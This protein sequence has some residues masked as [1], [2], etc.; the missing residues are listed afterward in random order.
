[1]KQRISCCFLLL[2]LSS[3]VVTAQSLTVTGIVTDA[4]TE[5]P[6][7]GVSVLLDGTSQGTLTDIDGKY[8]FTVPQNNQLTFTYI[9][10]Q[11]YKTSAKTNVLNIQLEPQAYEIEDVIVV[12]TR[13]KKS[14][15]TGAIGG[16]TEKQL[17]EVPTIDLST[18]MQGKVPG[19]FIARKDAAPGSDITVRVRGINSINYGQEPVYV[20]DGMVVDQGLKLINPDD[21]ASIEVLKDASSTALY[22]S[23]ASN[24]VVVITTKKGQKGEGQVN[25][26]GFVTVSKYQ[27]RLKQLN[28]RQLF[29]LRVD[30]YA[31]AY[32]DVNPNANRQDFINNSLLINDSETNIAFSMEELENGL[33]GIT[34][35]WVDPLI[36]TGFTQNHALSFSGSTGKTTYYLGFT[37]SDEKGIIKNTGYQ[38]YGGKVSLE[39]EVKSWLKIGTNTILSQG[40]RDILSGDEGDPYLTAFKGNPLQTIDKDRYYMYWQGVAQMGEYNPLL[41]LDIDRKEIHNRVLSS[42]YAEVNPLKNLFF[43][44]TFAVDI[45]NK[46]DNRYVPSHTGQSQRDNYEGLGWQWRSN[47]LYWQW[48][49][50]VSYE[51]TFNEKHRLFGLFSTSISKKDFNSVTTDGYKFPFDDLGY[52]NMGFASNKELNKI[53]SDYKASTLVSYI[54]R[55]NYS[56]ESKYL[57]T[58]TVRRDGSSKFAKDNRWGTFPSFSAAWNVQE[59]SFMDDITWLSQLKLRAG[60][61]IVGNQNIPEFTYLTLFNPQYSDG[62]IGL[63]VDGEDGKRRYQNE[64]VVWEK[65]KQWNVGLDAGVWNDRITFSFDAFHMT[66][67]DLLM[68]MN[69]YP[70]FGYDYTIANVAELKNR[71]V[72]FSINAQLIQTKDFSWS[73]SGNIAHDKNEIT[74]LYNGL[75]VIWNGGSVTDRENQLFVGQSLNNIYAYKLDR[76]AQV[77]DQE[78]LD[79]LNATDPVTGEPN[80][81]G[82]KKIRPGDYL[83]YDRNGDGKIRYLDDMH[84]V[85]KKDPKFYGGFSTYLTYKDF[86]FDAVFSYSYGAKRIS[87]V[88]EG[89]INGTGTSI[90]STEMLNRWTPENPST[91]VPRAW[92]GHY[93]ESRFNSWDFDISA[94]DASFLRC[95]AMTLAYDVPKSLIRKYASNLRVY[96]SAN[97]LFLIT[98]YKGYDPETGENYPLTRSFTFGLNVSF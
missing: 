89:M 40:N 71:G 31:N 25:Y 82:G 59:E 88:Y 39:Q 68:K 86:S 2:L 56:Y 51:R 97:N 28:A 7:I 98:P 70:S 66:N 30:A 45:F 21:I 37:Y 22:G 92:I 76:I 61:G 19:L 58:A 23:R 6:L 16:I 44:T 10:Y 53:N 62:Q 93:G 1:M 26:S 42:N 54:A 79:H 87:Y 81:E 20:V 72:E 47:D 78:Y 94:L 84:V 64:D 55:V 91:T 15:L 8:S 14:D 73:V 4:V 24:G 17:R 52:K 75:N 43:R 41:S 3:S 35:D 74:K 90:A 69:Y 5:E 60:Y 77:S 32:M 85:G 96:A 11:T 18:A 46:Q 33:N 48:D 80:I 95:A 50:S 36:Q 13:M 49:N 63:T 29:D 38:R 67:S 65:Q 27:N 57:L 12:G 34:S 9:G 83:P